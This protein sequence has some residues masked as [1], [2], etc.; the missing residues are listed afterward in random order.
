MRYTIEQ[1]ADIGGVIRAARKAQQLRQDDAAGSVGVSE[2]FMVKAERGA[3]TVQWG[4]VFQIL[5]GLGV[6][7]VVDIPDVSGELLERQSARASLRA[8]IRARRAAE[9]LLLRADAA[10]AAA[11]GTA[12]PASARVLAA[13]RLVLS[14]REAAGDAGRPASDSARANAARAVE[15]AR[16]L[17]ADAGERDAPPAA[18]ARTDDGEV[19]D[20]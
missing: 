11:A 15:I 16:R 5:Q 18:D 7:V 8:D 3:D 6:Q 10:Q 14:H 2:S 1:A 4:K 19:S 13:A 17:L 12:P 20:D 9:R